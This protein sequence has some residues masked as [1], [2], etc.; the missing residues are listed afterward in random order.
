M[1][2]QCAIASNEAPSG[3]GTYGY[4]ITIWMYWNARY[5]GQPASI[6]LDGELVA[7]PLPRRAL[8]LVAEWPGGLDMAPEPLYAEARRHLVQGARAAG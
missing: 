6:G 5:A 3:L 8:A 7:G 4:G 2:A 1:D